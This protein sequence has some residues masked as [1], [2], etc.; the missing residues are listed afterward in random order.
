M[1]S[2][3]SDLIA[4]TAF[5]GGAAVMVYESF[6]DVYQTSGAGVAQ[7]AVFYPRIVLAAIALLALL[8]AASALTRG[9]QP[10]KAQASAT[11]ADEGA[12]AFGWKPVI[13]IVMST[14]IYAALMPFAGFLVSTLLFVAVAPLLLGFRRWKVLALMIALFPLGSWL[15]FTR[16]IHIPL[17]AS[18][19][20]ILG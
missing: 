6:S 8:L 3:K 11:L 14:T 9:R 15:L 19:L 12:A 16:M 13:A 7:N 2:Q 20:S 18:T 4:A 5:L 10:S 1:A 17:P